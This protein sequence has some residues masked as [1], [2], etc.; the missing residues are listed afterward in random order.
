MLYILEKWLYNWQV[1]RFYIL[2]LFTL[3]LC[4]SVAI[5]FFV[6]YYKGWTSSTAYPVRFFWC[7][8]VTQAYCKRETYK[9]VKWNEDKFCLNF[10]FQFSSS[11]ENFKNYLN[12]FYMENK[13]KE[14]N[15]PFPSQCYIVYLSTS[16]LSSYSPSASL[17]H[18]FLVHHITY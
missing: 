12:K 13:K 4:L 2:S 5:F 11:N 6:G 14:K 10:M 15:Q 9:R 8:N 7:L 17:H 18:L 16:T 3:L 1:Y